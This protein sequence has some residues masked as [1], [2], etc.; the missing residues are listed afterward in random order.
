[1]RR[2]FNPDLAIEGILLT[3]HDGRTLL[4]QQVVREIQVH[5]GER[6]LR[7]VIPRNVRLGEAPSFGKPIILYDV[8]SSGAEAYLNLTREVISN[9]AR[10][11]REGN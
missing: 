4:S 3:M 8:R 9:A 10:G 5:F 11:S 6:V 7:T 2:N 1:M